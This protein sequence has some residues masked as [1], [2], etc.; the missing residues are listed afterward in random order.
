MKGTIIVCLRDMLAGQYGQ[1]PEQW[2]DLMAAAGLDRNRVILLSTDVDDASALALFA[3]AQRRYFKSHEELA[4]AYGNYWSVI[5][6][7][8]IYTSVYKGVMSARQFLLKLDKVHVQVTQTM[9]NARPPRFQ[10]EERPGG[11]L[12][13][14]YLSPRGLVHLYA[15]LAR[16]IGNYFDEKLEVKVM[17]E[18]RVSILFPAAAAA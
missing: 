1:T 16:G 15:G 17:D 2:K 4:D 10:Y 12:V 5:Y 18:S 11:E 7:P 14:H 6:A 9:E 8:R 3:E 13:V